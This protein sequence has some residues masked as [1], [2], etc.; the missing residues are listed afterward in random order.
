V[1]R[2]AP[3]TQPALLT[4][5]GV[6]HRYGEVVALHATDLDVAPGEC[7]ALLGPNGA[8]KTTLV[9]TIIGLVAPQRGTVRIGGGDPRHAAT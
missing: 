9:N 8:G 3:H 4:I 5:R 2:P 1:D 6:G 7:V